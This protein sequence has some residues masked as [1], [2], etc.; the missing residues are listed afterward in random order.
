MVGGR[1][2]DAAEDA[3]DVGTGEG[4]GV[5]QALV[6]ARTEDGE[7]MR[8]VEKAVRFRGLVVLWGQSLVSLSS[9]SKVEG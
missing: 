5:G 8:F 9:L 3:A 4:G 6:V 1:R 7:E 2:D